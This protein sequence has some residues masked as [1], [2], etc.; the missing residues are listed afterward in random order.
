MMV[1]VKFGV[2]TMRDREPFMDF[3]TNQKPK[4]NVVPQNMEPNIGERLF[5]T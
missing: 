3:G 1:G 2:N 4:R 5:T